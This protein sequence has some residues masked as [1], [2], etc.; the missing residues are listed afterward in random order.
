MIKQFRNFMLHFKVR[1]NVTYRK[2]SVRCVAYVP[3][4]IQI[5]WDH[6]LIAFQIVF[7]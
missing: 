2:T 3:G 6:I 4:E 7:V 5:I 1:S